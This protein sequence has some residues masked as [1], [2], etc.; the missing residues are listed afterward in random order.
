V[1][2]I[3][4]ACA[5]CGFLSHDIVLLSYDIVPF[6]VRGSSSQKIFSPVIC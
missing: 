2:P 3:I 4:A 1:I 6:G 5:K